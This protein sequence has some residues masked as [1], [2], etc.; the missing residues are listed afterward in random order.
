MARQPGALKEQQ[1]ENNLKPS[2]SEIPDRK[3]RKEQGTVQRQQEAYAPNG[4]FFMKTSNQI[5]R[6]PDRKRAGETPDCPFCGRKK[7]PGTSSPV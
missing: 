2:I 7:P 1:G 6:Q 5:R 4:F 3:T